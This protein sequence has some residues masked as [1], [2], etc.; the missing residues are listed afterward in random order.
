MDEIK[1]FKKGLCYKALEQAVL[2]GEDLIER[3]EELETTEG[4]TV[5]A[6]GYRKLELDTEQGS[7][8]C[9]NYLVCV[10]R[11]YEILNINPVNKDYRLKFSKAYKVLYSQ[12][13]D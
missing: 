9:R 5:A 10:E 12:Q 3:E 4:L 8:T 11:L 13:S 7:S 6:S 2:M 1:D